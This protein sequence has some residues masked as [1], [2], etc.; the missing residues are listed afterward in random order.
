MSISKVTRTSR[1]K[2]YPYF[3]VRF[4]DPGTGK[5]CI[6]YFKTQRE[7]R[8][9]EPSLRT[10]LSDGTFNREADS[11]TVAELVK[12]WRA[13]GYAPRLAKGTVRPATVKCYEL[14]LRRYILPRWGAVAVKAIRHG[15]LLQWRNELQDERTARKSGGASTVRNVLIVLG[16]LYRFARRD[17]LA[18][19]NPVADVPKPATAKRKREV[20]DPTQL[21]ALLAQLSGRSRIAVSLAGLTGMREGEVF[22]LR[23]RSVDLKEGT[24]SVEEQ[25]TLGQHGEVKTDAGQRVIGIDPALAAELAAWKLGRTP[26]C[27]QPDSLVLSTASGE[28]LSASNFLRRDFYPA[29]KAAALPRVTFH[30]LRHTALTALASSGQ[31]QGVVHRVSGHA[32]LATTLKFY[33]GLTDAARAGAADAI[34]AATEGLPD[35]HRTNGG[36]SGSGNAAK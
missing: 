12:R 2:A 15:D 24:I 35:K 14:A 3:A 31:P 18:A 21:P 5:E 6:K 17:F 9:A 19:H 27:K 10:K 16:A 8:A 7:A 29:L 4:T 13:A 22:G 26:E 30:S 1:G 23:W 34:R 33:V 32:N 36:G 20:L 28:A 11:I 25:Y